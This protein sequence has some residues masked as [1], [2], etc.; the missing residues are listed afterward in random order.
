MPMIILSIYYQGFVIKQWCKFCI[1]I[2]IVLLLEVSMSYF[3]KFHT[4]PM[5][6]NLLPL[7]G[8]LLLL[9]VISWTFL[10]TLFEKDKS[11]KLYKRTLSRLK[12][13]KKV[14]SGLLEKSNE[15][16][17]TPLDLGISIRNEDAMNSVLLV[18]SPN[19]NPCAEAF[20]IFEKLNNTHK[21]NLQII[22]TANN[23]EFSEDGKIVRHFLGI[24]DREKD[25]TEALNKSL[26]KWYQ[27]KK[28]EYY[29]FSKTYPLNGELSKQY[30]KVD[31]MFEWCLSQ[32]ITHTPTVFIN[33]K[34]LPRE[35]AIKDLETVLI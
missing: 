18:C 35:Y 29:I 13:N 32:G 16:I 20:P 23:D 26:A 25:S 7:L 10:K 24:F 28:K 34:E 31:Q 3:G 22:F 27:M 33:N 1:G 5:D 4:Y 8:I 14:F 9:P 2:K 12:G 6:N 11:A 17:K 19:C 21:I 15:V 30:D